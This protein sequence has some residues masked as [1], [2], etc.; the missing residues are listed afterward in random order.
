M[1]QWKL[2][3]LIQHEWITMTTHNLSHVYVI[4]TTDDIGSDID[5]KDS[6][7]KAKL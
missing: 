2:W 7:R 6:D 5:D 4:S 1:Q 3:G